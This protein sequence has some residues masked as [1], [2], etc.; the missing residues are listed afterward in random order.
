MKMRSLIA[1]ALV[2]AL[3]GVA[4]AQ[5]VTLSFA[6]WLPPTHPLQ[7]TGFEPWIESIKE[8][9]G[10]RIAIDIYPA[11][12]LGAAADHYDMARDGIADIAWINPG[13]QPGRFPLHAIGELPL[14]M[15]DAKSGSRAFDAWYRTYAPEEMSDVYYCMTHS[16]DPGTFHSKEPVRTPADI[17]GKNVRPAH[18]TMARWVSLMGG[19]SVQVPAPEARE[20]IAKGAADMITFPWGSI[21]IF[22]IDKEVKHHLD[23]PL[24][25]SSQAIVMNKDM[26]EG[27]PDDLRKVIDDHCTPEW[28][29]KVVSGWVDAEAAGRQRMIDEGHTLYKP[30]AEDLAAWRESAAPLTEEWM[31]SVNKRGIDAQAAY[32]AY[33]ASLREA[34]ALMGEN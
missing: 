14:M 2:A 23:T 26:V 4:C 25:V 22:G 27:L 7:P 9:S 12:Q 20:A 28:T 13:Y 8:A 31:A 3:P 6:H 34:G 11:Q 18:A 33:V 29:E 1:T 5:E 19:A 32:D 30:T 24:Y 16:H 21:F 10:G 17:A 15:S